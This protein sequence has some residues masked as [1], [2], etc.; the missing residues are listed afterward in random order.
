MTEQADAP[1]PAAVRAA[2]ADIDMQMDR[3]SD[4]RQMLEGAPE[5]LQRE[6][7]PGLSN[8]LLT[9]KAALQRLHHARQLLS[10]ELE[11]QG[12]AP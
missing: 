6:L 12:L 11:R 3:L 8:Q 4:V 5:M 7:E 9:I 10:A 1:D 2:M